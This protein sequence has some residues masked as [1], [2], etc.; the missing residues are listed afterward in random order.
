MASIGTHQNQGACRG[1]IEN[2]T[3]VKPSG[4]QRTNETRGHVGVAPRTLFV[5]TQKPKAIAK[6][7]QVFWTW[8]GERKPAAATQHPA[9]FPESSLARRH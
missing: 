4:G 6:F 7:N 2:R 1:R 9:P 8:I 3:A 5:L